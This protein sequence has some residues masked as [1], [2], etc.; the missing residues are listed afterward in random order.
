MLPPHASPQAKLGATNVT[1]FTFMTTWLEIERLGERLF[2]KDAGADNLA[3]MG[4]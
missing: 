4:A 2:L 1:V 3:G